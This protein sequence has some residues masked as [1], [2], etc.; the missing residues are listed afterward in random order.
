MDENIPIEEEINI[1]MNQGSQWT[2]QISVA[3]GQLL[4]TVQELLREAVVRKITVLDKDGKTLVEIPLVAGVLGVAVMGYWTVLALIAAWFTEVSI[5]IVREEMPAKAAEAEPVVS[6]E[7]LNEMADRAGKSISEAAER[8]GSSLSEW[9]A[10]ASKA[11]S[12]MAARAAD[13]LEPK[14]NGNG[15]APVA[16]ATAEA[17]A[18]PQRCQAL[19][20]AGTQCKRNA[21]PGSDFCST[22]QPA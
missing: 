2:E 5:H 8:A 15:H 6:G 4:S 14:P 3:G 17:E 1:D 19:T 9:M 11:A 21:L 12:D 10:R 13:S 7:S 20:K 16:E 18:E 22:H